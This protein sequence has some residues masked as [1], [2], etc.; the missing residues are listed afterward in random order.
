V[1]LADHGCLCLQGT[2]PPADLGETSSSQQGDQQDGQ[3]PRSAEVLC[4]QLRF[5]RFGLVE[6]IHFQ[7]YTL[8]LLD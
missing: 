3:A 7:P 4:A 8:M 5:A 6:G 1:A 2:M